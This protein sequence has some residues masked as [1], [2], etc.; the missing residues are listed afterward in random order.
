MKKGRV[1]VELLLKFIME[2]VGRYYDGKERTVEE[3]EM[4]NKNEAD[5]FKPEAV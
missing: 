4:Y 5:F 3:E 2:I 1:R